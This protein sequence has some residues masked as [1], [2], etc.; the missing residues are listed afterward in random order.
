M[1]ITELCKS[2]ELPFISL[3]IVSEEP[4]FL[5]ILVLSNSFPGILKV[6]Q[7][8]SVCYLYLADF[9]GLLLFVCLLLT[10]TYQSLNHFEST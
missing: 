6:F 8:F 4:G 10:Q 9:S 3:C 5:V 2:L 7:S 1:R